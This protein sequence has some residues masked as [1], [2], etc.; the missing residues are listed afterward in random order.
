MTKLRLA[1]RMLFCRHEWLPL[2]KFGES[3]H[4]QMVH[5]CRKCEQCRRTRLNGPRNGGQHDHVG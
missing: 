2:V 1:L 3:Y 4:W 5:I